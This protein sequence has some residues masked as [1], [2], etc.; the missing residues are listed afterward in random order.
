MIDAEI[1]NFICSR[2][3]S[4][5]TELEPGTLS[6]SGR[7]FEIDI[8]RTGSRTRRRIGKITGGH[9]DTGLSHEKN[10]PEALERLFHSPKVR[11][12]ERE[13]LREIQD[14]SLCS[15]GLAE[16][17]IMRKD[18]YGSDGKTVVRT[19]YVMGYTLYLHLERKKSRTREREKQTIANW[20]ARL[21]A[22]LNERN[23]VKIDLA[24]EENRHLLWNFIED[25]AAKIEHCTVVKEVSEVIWNKEQPWQGR[26]LEFYVDFIIALAEIAAARAHFDW[27]EIGARYYREIGGSKRFDPY[28][29]EF[30]EEAEEQIGCPLPLLGLCSAGTVTPI[31]FA[32]ELSG[33][34][35]FAYP[36][37]FLHVVT[38][39]TV[40]RTEFQTV[41]RTLWLT[42]NRAVLTRMSAEPDFLRK[43]GSLIIG[44]DG[45]LRSGHRKLIKDVLAG[46][47]SIRQIIVWCD[48]D[49]AGLT[50]SR[51]VQALL[52]MAA[53][54]AVKWILPDSLNRKDNPAGCVFRTWDAYEAEALA[55]LD[56]RLAGEQEAEM[57]DTDSWN[58]WMEI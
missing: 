53:P 7:S 25:I 43:S 39:V 24:G 54:V 31:F 55:R 2:Y 13:L 48:S 38:D 50:I 35:G 22:I 52:Q 33:S 21:G 27:K 51:N 29:V 5:G 15:G 32:G 34:G 12:G 30:L 49:R 58:L 16:G 26:K 56:R 23:T 4:K 3:L 11:K 41:C 37:G 57:G 36:Q 10:V 17:W 47:E 40:W 19:E 14:E 1:V 20:N 8:F 9:A 28:K 46:S 18:L 6:E 44:L 45:Q 42:E